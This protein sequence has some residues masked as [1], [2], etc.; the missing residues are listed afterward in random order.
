MNPE[1]PSVMPELQPSPEGIYAWPMGAPVSPARGTP[2][3]LE[4]VQC[5]LCRHEMGQPIAVGEDFEYRSSPDTFLAVRCS[6]CGL[7][8]LNPRPSLSEL[9]RIYPPEYHAYDF[10]PARYGLAYWVRRRLEARRVLDWCRGLGSDARILD[11]GC[12]DG[13]HLGILR[14]F[15]GPTWRLEGV[16]PDAHA[17]E[18]ARRAGLQ[19][20]QGVIQNLPLPASQYDLVLLIATLEHVDDPLAVLT[21]VRSLLRPGGRVGVVT[22]NI[23]TLDFRLFGKRHWGGYHFPRH[24]NLFDWNT[25]RALALRSGLEV[26]KIGT[27]LSPVNWVYSIRNLLTDWGAPRWLVNRFSLRGAGALTLFTLV[28]AMCQSLGRGG[29]LRATFRRRN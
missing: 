18:T 22:D 9:H 12:G 27:I 8:Y 13:F 15:G 7:V 25:L 1:R 4:S 16:E 21:S 20:H 2:L 24:W 23:E 10:S 5:G 17:A 3:R 19:V 14:D 11:V 6:E 26:E 29:F 28:D